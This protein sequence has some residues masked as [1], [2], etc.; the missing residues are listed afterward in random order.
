MF[1][2]LHAAL[3]CPRCQGR[4]ETAIEFRFGLL[5]LR[6][7]RLGDAL[8]WSD[9]GDGLR[10]PRRPPAD[11]N[12]SGDGHAECPRCHKDFFVEIAV[13]DGRL[14]AVAIDAKPGHTV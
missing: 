14:D 4:A 1:N 7:Y 8:V 3:V 10:H 2:I 6:D 11:G 12:F 9:R 5:E 13:R